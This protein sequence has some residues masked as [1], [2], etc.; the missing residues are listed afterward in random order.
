MKF[1]EQLGIVTDRPT[2]LHFNAKP[3]LLIQKTIEKKE[4]RLTKDGTLVVLTG[5]HTGRCAQDRYVVKTKSTEDRI[6]WENAINMM[7]TENF[8]KLKTAAVKHLN[9]QK[10][11][12]VSE[13]CVGADVVHNVGVRLV[14]G[15]PSHNFFANNLFREKIRELDERDYTILHVPDMVINPKDFGTRAT[16]VIVTDFDQKITI[17][18]GTLYAGEIKKTMF[19]VLNYILPD[20]K[21]LPMH[22][23]A[24]RL[25]NGETGVFFGL[26]GTGKTT[27]S[28]DLGTYL[29]GDDEHGLSDEGVFNFENG[30]YAKTYKLTEDTE[31]EI[32]RASNRFG[33]MLENVALNEKTG[34]VDYFDKCLTE[35]GRSSYPL[36]FIEELEP[37]SRGSV[38]KNIFFLTADAFGVLPPV[39]KLTKEQ[40]MFYFVLGYTAKLAGTEIGVTEPKAAFSPCFGAPFMLRHPRVYADLLGHYLEKHDIKVWLINTGWT[41]GAYGVGERFPLKVTREIVRAIQKGELNTTELTTDPV[42]KLATPV[43][44]PNVETKVLNP[45]TTWKDQ[46]A[47]D[48]QAKKLEESFRKQMEKFGSFI[49]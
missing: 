33:A 30:C 42:F 23:G 41:G 31:P 1:Y 16:E 4:G 48:V 27:L 44:V 29:I 39:A 22:A 7:T 24:N 5:K 3:H 38:P 20:I 32:W 28:T 18:V 47:Y 13:R 43:A 46:V 34:E 10:E 12:Y 36:E 2:S 9:E 15:H 25:A 17:I 14:T 37:S 45:K 26:S 49:S 6:W 19:S 21:V 40:A 11:L 35:N 8:N